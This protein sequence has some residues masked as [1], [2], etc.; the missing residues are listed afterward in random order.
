MPRA[1]ISVEVEGKYTGLEKSWPVGQG[2][3]ISVSIAVPDETVW[4]Q[5]VTQAAG[6]GIPSPFFTQGTQYVSLADL[7]KLRKVQ[8]DIESE[9]TKMLV[10]NSAKAGRY[11]IELTVHQNVSDKLKD[12]W[13]WSKEAT[14]EAVQDVKDVADKTIKDVKDTVKKAFS[15]TPVIVVIVGLW[16]FSK[17]GGA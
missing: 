8:T 11:A 13:T 14:V 17:K 6:K 10:A 7:H 2:V 9:L 12:Y 3:Q 15:W 1:H 4:G 5:V 16:L